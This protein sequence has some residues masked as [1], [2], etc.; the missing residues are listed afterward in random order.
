[1]SQETPMKHV[2][3][4]ISSAV[5]LN[6]REGDPSNFMSALAQAS[7]VSLLGPFQG[8]I[9]RP[10]QPKCASQCAMFREVSGMPPEKSICRSSE[11]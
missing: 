11:V 9:L 8:T 1:M 6:T 10:S 4:V 2:P 5:S 3:H 7:T